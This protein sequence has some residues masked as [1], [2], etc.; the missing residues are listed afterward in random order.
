MEEK[1]VS[2][3]EKNIRKKIHA[4]VGKK[5]V[6]KEE[7]NRQRSRKKFPLLKKSPRLEIEIK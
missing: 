5:G 6:K 3:R 2:E 4:K 1:F 7:K